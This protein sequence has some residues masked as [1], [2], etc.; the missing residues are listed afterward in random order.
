MPNAYTTELFI[1]VGFGL[2]FSLAA[3]L[4]SFLNKRKTQTDIENFELKGRL[5]E[6]QRRE[7]LSRLQE[8]VRLETAREKA[9]LARALELA[10]AETRNAQILVAEKLTKITEVGIQTHENTNSARTA[11]EKIEAELRGK[12]DAQVLA[13][14]NATT[15]ALLAAQVARELA[16]RDLQSE[17]EKILVLT[18]QIAALTPQ[19]RLVSATEA[20]P[21]DVNIVADKEK[22]VP[23]QMV[24]RPDTKEPA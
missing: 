9:D 10:A 11:M 3:Y 15:A 18:Q 2:I 20:G 17:R 12:L 8:Q 14:S 16:A 7:E 6:S 13:S 21:V 19:T 1:G 23:V 5:A 22:P 4:T 24:P